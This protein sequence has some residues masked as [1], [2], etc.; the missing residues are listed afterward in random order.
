MNVEELR[1]PGADRKSLCFVIRVKRGFEIETGKR[2]NSF[3]DPCSP[4]RWKAGTGTVAPIALTA[5]L[6]RLRNR[7]YF[8]YL[9]SACRRFAW[10]CRNLT[11]PFRS[12]GGDGACYRVRA[13]VLQL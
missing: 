12:V 3:H 1:A 6:I 5:N 10:I 13:T 7:A 4:D 8:A 9:Q 2:E 11:L